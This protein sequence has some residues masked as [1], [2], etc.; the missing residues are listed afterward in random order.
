MGWG[1]GTLGMQE[2]GGAWLLA[3]R[4]CTYGAWHSASM[5]ACYTGSTE[6]P[7]VPCEQRAPDEWPARAHRTAP[8]S[9][10][11]DAP[12]ARTTARLNSRL[13]AEKD[14][15][16]ETPHPAAWRLHPQDPGRP[17]RLA[18][19]HIM[20]RSACEHPNP[21]H[22]DIATITAHAHPD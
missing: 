18:R 17:W 11:I 16:R 21:H 8:P 5:A 7:T 12:I 9:R 19:V 1:T 14:R 4:R 6:V 22:E 2:E 13:L 15:Q 3:A 20:D 10:R